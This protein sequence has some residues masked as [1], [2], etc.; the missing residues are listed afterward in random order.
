MSTTSALAAHLADL[1]AP[2]L[3]ATCVHLLPETRR[4]E[5]LDG[6]LRPAGVFLNEYQGFLT[7]EQQDAVRTLAALLG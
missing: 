7:P 3:L 4:G 5:I 6:D 1:S 2:A